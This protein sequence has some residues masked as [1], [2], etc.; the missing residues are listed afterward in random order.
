MVLNH[1]G[2]HV[3][4]PEFQS[5]IGPSGWTDNHGRM[6]ESTYAGDYFCPGFENLAA[7]LV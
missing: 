6:R 1:C 3:G 5:Q 7:S 4:L 2:E